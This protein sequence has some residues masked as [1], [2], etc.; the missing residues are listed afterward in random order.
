LR[1]VY[2][3][4]GEPGFRS[5]VAEVRAEMLRRAEG[6]FTAAAIGSIKTFT[7]LRDSAVSESVRL[8]AARS[9]I[10]LGCKVRESVELVE[11]MAAVET[12]LG[13]LLTTE[14]TPGKDQAR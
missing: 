9:I 1:T 2:R 5:Q 6:M 12:Q 14:T 11:R 10:E 3:R 7:T 8:G 4:L 13:S